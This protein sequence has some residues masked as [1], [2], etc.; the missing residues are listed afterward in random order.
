MELR[1]GAFDATMP[2]KDR[3]TLPKRQIKTPSKEAILAVSTRKDSTD[4][5]SSPNKILTTVENN[6]AITIKQSFSMS[7]LRPGSP[8]LKSVEYS[9][10][11]NGSPLTGSQ[12]IS[13]TGSGDGGSE[14]IQARVNS[15]KVSE[16]LLALNCG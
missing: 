8:V 12:A 5:T 10:A 16:H 3:N 13:T 11:G 2:V 7:S 9:A 4:S 6:C 15:L 14:F 1:G